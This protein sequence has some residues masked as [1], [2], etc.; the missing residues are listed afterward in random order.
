MP[1]TARSR[2]D[3]PAPEAGQSAR[4]IREYRLAQG[5]PE[6]SRLQGEACIVCGHHGRLAALQPAG[7][8]HTVAAG[9]RRLRWDVRVCPAHQEAAQ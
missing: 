1:Q 6:V 8:V 7:T 3:A 4:I 5:L 2:A 9:G